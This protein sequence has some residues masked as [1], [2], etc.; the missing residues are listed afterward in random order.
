MER[1]RRRKSLGK[2][3]LEREG[4]VGGQR[5]GREIEEEKGRTEGGTGDRGRKREDRGGDGR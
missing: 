1:G 5:E 3:E 4:R 2:E